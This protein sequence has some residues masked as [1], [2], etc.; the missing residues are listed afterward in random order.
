MKVNILVQERKLTMLND[1]IIAK[2]VIT[3]LNE[4]GLIDHENVNLSDE[5]IDELSLEFAAF[6]E[7]ER[8][9]LKTILKMQTWINN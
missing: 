3:W 6:P 9:M 7:S 2:N 4:N 1:Y 5:K 8:E